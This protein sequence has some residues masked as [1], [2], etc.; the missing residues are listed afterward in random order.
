VDT[1]TPITALLRLAGDGDPAAREE[2]FQLLYAE[3]RRLAAAQRRR[4]GAGETLDTTALVHET[5]LR[6]VGRLDVDWNGRQHFFCTAARTMRDIL[7]DQARRARARKRGGDL[8]RVDLERVDF[9]VEFRPD[10]LL[11]LDDALRRLEREDATD[12][13][14]VLLRYFGGLSFPEVSEVLGIPLRTVER[15]WRFCRS[16]LARELTGEEPT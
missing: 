10:H 13:E 14:V 4:L 2:L 12:H 15:R 6:L 16:W 1:S 3:L 5:Y 8:Q 11:A 7:V 9:A